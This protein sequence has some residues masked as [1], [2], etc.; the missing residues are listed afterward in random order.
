MLGENFSLKK[1]WKDESD[2][3]SIHLNA[4]DSSGQGGCEESKNLALCLRWA[5]AF[6]TDESR[7]TP[8]SGRRLFTQNKTIE[9][10]TYECEAD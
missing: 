7:R 5:L 4:G 3:G 2:M 8:V 1:G 6:L 9:R 10:T